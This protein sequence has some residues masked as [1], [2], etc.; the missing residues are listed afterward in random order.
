[1]LEKNNTKLILFCHQNLLQIKEE[2]VYILMY[3]YKNREDSEVISQHLQDRIV[4]LLIEIMICST[5]DVIQCMKSC[6]M[7]RTFDPA[8]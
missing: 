2:M 7:K 3:E 6:W 5:V 1:M 8:S 4:M